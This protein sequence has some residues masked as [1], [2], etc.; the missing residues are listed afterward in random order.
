MQYMA[1]VDFPQCVLN[2]ILHTVTL[3]VK[4]F[5]SCT[6]IFQPQKKYATVCFSQAVQKWNSFSLRKV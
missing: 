2:L 6:D 4:A 3:E 5:K 1:L